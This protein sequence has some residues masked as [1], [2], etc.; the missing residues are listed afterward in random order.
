M[1]EYAKFRGQ[2]IKIGTC[3]SMYYLRYEDRHKVEAKSGNVD[4]ANDKNLFF[5]LPFPDEDHI[6]PGNYEDYNRGLRMYQTDERGR[7]IDFNFDGAENFSLN[8][9]SIQLHHASGILFSIPCYHGEKLPEITA[10]GNKINVF[11][12]GKTH[13]IELA[14]V[15]VTNAGNVVPVVRCMHCGQLWSYSPDEWPKILNYIPDTVLRE[16]LAAHYS[17]VAV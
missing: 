6:E 13:S 1:G 3:E 17:P 14:F 9:G 8:P 15:K 5:R 10:G 16:R 2:E 7:C 12:N 11:W 4:P